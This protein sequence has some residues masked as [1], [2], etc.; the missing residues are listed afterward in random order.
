LSDV[1]AAFGVETTIVLSDCMQ[2][3]GRGIGPALEALDVLALLQQAPHAPADLQERVCRLAGALLE[4][5]RK[6]GQGLGASLAAQTLR[7]GRAW[8][9]FQRICEAQ[10][11]MRTPPRASRRRPLPAPDAGLV[12]SIDNRK[13]ARLA[14]LAGAPE[15]KAAGVEMHVRLGEVVA[16]GQPLCTVHAETPGELDYAIEY[17]ASTEDIVRIEPR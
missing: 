16:A 14:K 1:A 11:G 3:V 13:I 4:L 8:D 12:A 15:A 10:G 5:G 6:A 7:S 2:P 17:A 9:K